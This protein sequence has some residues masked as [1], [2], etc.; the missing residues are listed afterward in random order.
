MSRSDGITDPHK[1]SR[2][3]LAKRDDPF[4]DGSGREGKS[5]PTGAS[6][7]EVRLTENK[8]GIPGWPCHNG[9]PLSWEEVYGPSVG[10][11]VY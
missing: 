1:G 3:L 5:A 2:A 6:F 7:A 9:V 8:R 4:G 10:E 11:C